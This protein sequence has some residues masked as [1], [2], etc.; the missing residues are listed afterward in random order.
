MPRLC[1]TCT[2]ATN[3]PRF[4]NPCAACCRFVP[5][6]KRLCSL[7]A[8][9]VLS[10][11]WSETEDPLDPLPES[12]EFEFEFGDEEWPILLWPM[13]PPLPC[14]CCA[15]SGTP[16]IETNN[17]MFNFLVFIF[18]VPSIYWSLGECSNFPT[19][20]PK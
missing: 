3:C 19:L 7:L 8:S 18:Y 2:A 1:E 4:L 13:P 14:P 11:R 17:K 15:Y 10:S 12:C 16:S 5:A 6:G 9:L 20:T